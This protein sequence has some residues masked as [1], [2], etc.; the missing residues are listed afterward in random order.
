MATGAR[1]TESF[2]ARERRSNAIV[3]SVAQGL[4]TAAVAIDLTLTGLTG[5]Q[6]APDKALATL[7][8]ALITVASAIA[9][10][11]ASLLMQR[12]GRRWGFVIGAA[13]GALGGLVS[14]WAILHSDFWL[15]CAGTAA[16]GIFQAFAQYY[17]L[18]AAD[19]VAPQ[20]K[21]RV[22]SMVL[23]GGVIA[24]I[25][26][27]ALAAWSKNL[28]PTLFAGSYLMVFLLGIASVVVLAFGFR[29]VE[30]ETI[31]AHEEAAARSLITVFRQPMSLAALANNVIGGVVMM[32]V[33]T[34]A[35][36]AAVANHHSIDDGAN[37]IQW[38][39]VGMFAPSFV[40]GHLIKRYGMPSVLFA[41]I[42]LSAACTFIATA[43]SSLLAFYAA[44]L[45]LGVGW[46]FMFVGGTALLA[47]SHTPAERAEVQ[48]VAELIRN[49]FTAAA[50]LVAGP[51]LERFGWVDLNL[52][53]VP[54]L[55][56]AAVLTF[57]W[58]RDERTSGQIST[59]VESSA[60]LKTD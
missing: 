49:I 56:V 12:I 60:S 38:H 32:F 41:G 22:I 51:I 1:I 5:Y 19:S 29:D 37:I 13:I 23:A 11:L 14:V 48:G 43:S 59:G 36:L 3:L 16:V 17:R 42:V 40:A 26:G 57:V 31:P 25:L 4:Y 2:D 50:T 15:F 35:P 18:A 28:F 53:N 55:T 9:T 44:L 20:Q 8:F 21:A 30:A 33:M 27:P 34:A 47:S 6:L 7:P 45:C 58:V 52:V 54:L 46:N 10:L 39:L 24:A